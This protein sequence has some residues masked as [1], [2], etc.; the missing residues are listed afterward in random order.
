MSVGVAAHITAA[1]PGGPRYDANIAPEARSSVENGIWLCETHARQVDVDPGY[2]TVDLLR[3]WKHHAEQS[4]R[5]LIGR[6][7]SAQALDVVVEVVPHR[8]ADGG[9]VVVGTTNLPDAT[10]LMV[11]LRRSGE[12]RMLGQA[13]THVISGTFLAG[14]FT[15]RGRAH[16]AG[17]YAVDVVSYFNEAWKQPAGVLS[18][19]GPQ[20]QN[21]AG[22]NA[23]P[24]D[25]EV[26]DPEYTV[27]AV[28]E[29]VA[30]PVHGAPFP[31]ASDIDRAVQ[32]VQRATLT[33]DGRESSGSVGETVEWFM[34]LQGLRVRDGWSGAT[35]A[36]GLIRVD[37]SFWNG[38]RP[39]LATWVV[40]PCTGEV[41]YR[42]RHAK[43]LS[44]LSPE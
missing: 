4:A 24:S 12:T 19:V 20:G 39:A 15:E 32:T 26:E 17:W 25:P 44:W 9:L 34:G 35:E 22:R 42:N 1:A 27:H 8:L 5:S 18:I 21:L 41:R 29:C 36:N 11:T 6:P 3:A 10:K 13:S 43:W 40:L 7:V 30:P 14:A 38:N 16:P 2:Y 31:D 28:V 23:E 37:Y 33:V